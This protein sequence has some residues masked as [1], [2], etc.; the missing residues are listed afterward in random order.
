MPSEKEIEAAARAM[1]ELDPLIDSGESIDG[2]QVTPGG[3]LSWKQVC[4]LE[5]ADEWRKR[6]Y[7]ALAAAAKAREE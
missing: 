3:K 5:I 2:F 7:A 4:E 6:A 1:Y